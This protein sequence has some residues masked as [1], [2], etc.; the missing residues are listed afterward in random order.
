[1]TKDTEQMHIMFISYLSEERDQSCVLPK[2]K[3]KSKSKRTAITVKLSEFSNITG[4]QAF[5]LCTLLRARYKT[6]ETV[7]K[8]QS[9]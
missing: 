1:M 5:C 3:K 8:E 9:N 4:I 2:S 7:I 6:Y